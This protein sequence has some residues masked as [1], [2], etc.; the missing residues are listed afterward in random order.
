MSVTTDCDSNK[1]CSIQLFNRINCGTSKI[2]YKLHSN[3]FLYCSSNTLHFIITKNV[4][5][6]FHFFTLYP[7]QVILVPNY[8]NAFRN[9]NNSIYICSQHLLLELQSE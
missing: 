9:T 5:L 4:I 1:H 3:F 6:L 8:L 2:L 7:G